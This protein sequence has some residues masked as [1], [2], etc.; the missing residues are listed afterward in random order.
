[1]V[2][3]C[4]VFLFWV[5]VS[6]ILYTYLGYPV[7]LF[8]IGFVLRKPVAKKPCEPFVSVVISAFNEEKAIEQK[9]LNLLELD[10]PEDK[11]EILVGSD[12]ASD[13]TDQI[14][15][16]FHSTRIRF[17][18]F[19]KNFGKPHVLKALVEEAR[20]DILLFTD[21]R[22][23]LDRG[24]L[25]A[26][27]SN[28][29][30]PKVGSVSGELYLKSKAEAVGSVGSGMDA[31][32]RYEKFLR[33][34]ESEIGSMLGA[35]GAIYAIR[36][37]LFPKIL[38]ADI[39]VDDMYIPFTAISKGYRAVFESEALAFDRVSERSSEEF[40]RK[41]RTLAGNYQIFA[42]FPELLNPLK[43]PI[44]W[45]LISHKLLRLS[46]PFFLL[47]V[48]V[49]NLFLLAE[50]FYVFTLVAQLV[51]YGLAGYEALRVRTEVL[52]KGIGYLP[53]MFC[54]LNYSAVMGLIR[55]LKGEQKVTWERAYV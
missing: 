10:Y 34:K 51:F 14:V 49:S 55:F 24:A 35:T 27:V 6:A 3:M 37:M 9:L 32:W 26:L 12:G 39:L 8:L 18:R 47:V 2:E 40:K 41:V 54:L 4:L 25:K 22:Q 11:L 20:G 36:K 53:Y 43:S 48:F 15:S 46:V 23:E 1:M 45:Q 7:A 13:Q 38:P 30:D 50:P 52:Y 16:K 17:F 29:S 44:G 28:F 5:S 21:T 33:K 31:Y 42:H 19:V